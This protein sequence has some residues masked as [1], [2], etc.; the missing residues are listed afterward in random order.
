[1][2]APAVPPAAR[3]PANP[4]LLDDWAMGAASVSFRL[5]P[6]LRARGELLAAGDRSRG[7]A[8]LLLDEDPTAPEVLALTAIIDGLAG[9]TGGAERKLT[10]LVYFTPDRYQGLVR[11][12]AIWERVA[13]PRLAC[14]AWVRAARWR[15]EPDDP[16][17]RRAVACT[18]RDP[19]AGD[20]RAITAYV[21]QRAPAERRAALARELDLD[22]A[23]VPPDASATVPVSGRRA[24]DP[25]PCDNAG[26]PR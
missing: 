3:P 19:D 13:Q 8:E 16:T 18:R 15:D 6:V 25:I 11:A 17:W 23:A 24:G 26:S 9:R 22:P 4:A 10:D 21:L 1:M 5:L 14:A 7:W 2:D 12:A 20:F